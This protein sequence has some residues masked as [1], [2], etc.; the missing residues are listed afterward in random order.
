MLVIFSSQLDGQ[1]IILKEPFIGTKEEIK[2][3][4]K[5]TPMANFSLLDY[6]SSRKFL[7]PSGIQNDGFVFIDAYE[8]IKLNS[9]EKK[10][11]IGKYIKSLRI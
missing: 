1:K 8:E 5:F 6:R 7:H 10:Q 4:W 9:K 3:K 2:S 11:L